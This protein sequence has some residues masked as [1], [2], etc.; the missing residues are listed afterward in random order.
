MAATIQRGDRPSDPN[1][2]DGFG[3]VIPEGTVLITGVFGTFN[4]ELPTAVGSN[5]TFLIK[6]SGTGNVVVVAFAGEVIED[7]ASMI[8]PPHSAMTIQSTGANWIII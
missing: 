2:I 1:A 7:D 3:R 5:S 6:N 8:L 4:V